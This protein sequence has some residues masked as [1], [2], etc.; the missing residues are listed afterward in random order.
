MRLRDIPTAPPA[1]SL[2]DATVFYFEQ[3]Y[4]ETFHRLGEMQCFFFGGQL[5]HIIHVAEDRRGK[6]T[7]QRAD[8]ITPLHILRYVALS[9]RFI[10]IPLLILV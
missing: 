8:S 2:L 10:F 4:V 1:S 3:E 7:A 9:S 6:T 5:R